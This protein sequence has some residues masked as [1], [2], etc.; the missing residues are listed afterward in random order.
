[1]LPSDWPQEKALDSAQLKHRSQDTTYETGYVY[2]KRQYR[3]P[4]QRRYQ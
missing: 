1:M 2:P 3:L 4:I